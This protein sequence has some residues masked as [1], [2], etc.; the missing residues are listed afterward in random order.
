MDRR[1]DADAFHARQIDD[2]AVVVRAVPR[3][4][5]AA[6]A[7]GERQSVR[8]RKLH[9]HLNIGHAGAAGDESRTPID[10]AVPHATSLVVGRVIARDQLTAKRCA[11]R[12]DVLV[13]QE[14]RAGSAGGHSVDSK[15][16]V[17]I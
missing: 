6:V 12:V 10:V 3:C 1:V 11:Q 16:L 4:A 2:Q 5:V 14:A 7:D 13:R 15:S 17:L 8:A 9:R